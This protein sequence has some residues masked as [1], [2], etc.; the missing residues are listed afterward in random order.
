[1]VNSFI[2]QFC[3]TDPA[4]GTLYD[5]DG[6]AKSVDILAVVSCYCAAIATLPNRATS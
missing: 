1:M 2:R 6:Q 5:V 3:N 4:A